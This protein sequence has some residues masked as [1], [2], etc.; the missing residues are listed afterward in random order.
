MEQQA[1]ERGIHTCAL[2]KIVIRIFKFHFLLIQSNFVR[3][4]FKVVLGFVTLFT[5][6]VL[7]GRIEGTI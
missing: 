7:H 3:N 6:L 2:K 5:F 4:Y 1:Q